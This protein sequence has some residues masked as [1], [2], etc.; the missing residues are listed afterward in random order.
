MRDPSVVFYS[1]VRCLL[2]GASLTGKST[3]L[4]KFLQNMD[5]LMDV[6][7]EKVYF[8]YKI[9]QSLYEQ[10]E[11]CLG[12][13]IV[14]RQ[15][16]PSESDILEIGKSSPGHKVICI[17]D[18][19]SDITQPVVNLFNAY[20]HHLFCSV[21]VLLHRLFTPHNKFVRDLSLSSSHLILRRC[22]RDQNESKMLFRQFGGQKAKSYQAA[23]EKAMSERAYNYVVLN[24][25]QECK[26]EY[27]LYTNVFPE[28]YPPIFYIVK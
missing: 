21:F 7:P 2:S 18:Q 10:M 11:T 5:T 4:F 19:G 9:H 24:L 15:G 23:F 8:F 26:D 13:R 20:A 17:D 12:D 25:Q 28:E 22:V 16:L 1:P 6:P 27:R 3:W 14:F